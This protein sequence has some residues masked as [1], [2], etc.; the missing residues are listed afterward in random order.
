MENKIVAI[1]TT[2]V[3][4]MRNYGLANM[5]GVDVT[6]SAT[7]T[8]PASMYLDIQGAYSWMRAIDL[9]DPGSKSYRNQLPYT[10][11]HSGNAGLLLHTPWLNV[12]YTIVAAGKRY[13]LAQNIP[14]NEV[15]AYH[16]H[17]LTLSR[18]LKMGGCSLSV[19]ASATN[20]LDNN[21]DVIRYYPMPG[22]AFHITLEFTL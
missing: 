15:E 6:A 1:P 11:R 13:I 17:T 8:L 22:R 4:K 3:W 16:D 10:P 7:L 12:G 19:M 21:Y 14:S 2:Y 20:L 18:E 5:S 9:T